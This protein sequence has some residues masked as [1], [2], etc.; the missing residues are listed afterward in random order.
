[1]A[2]LTAASSTLAKLNDGDGNRTAL[3]TRKVNS[4]LLWV[5]INS[6]HGFC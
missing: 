2:A 1:M 6:S 5:W 4:L 3:T